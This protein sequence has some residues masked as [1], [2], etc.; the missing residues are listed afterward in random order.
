M[1]LVDSQVAQM[2]KGCEGYRTG[3]LSPKKDRTLA[4]GRL[5]PF[6][7]PLPEKNIGEMEK[8]KRGKERLGNPFL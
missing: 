4:G 1:E 6:Y 5:V 7:A 2:R 8:R 3:G